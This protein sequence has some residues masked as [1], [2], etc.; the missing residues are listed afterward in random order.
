VSSL[1]RAGKARILLGVCGGGFIND[2]LGLSLSRLLA[3]GNVLALAAEYELTFIVLTRPSDLSACEQLRA[4]QKLKEIFTAK[5]ISIG[6]Y[7]SIALWLF[8]WRDYFHAVSF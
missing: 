8:S 4:L 7:S 1:Q 6:K 2:F 5:F 3:Q